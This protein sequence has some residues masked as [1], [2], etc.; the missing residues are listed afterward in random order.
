MIDKIK[1]LDIP[2]ASALSYSNDSK[3]CPKIDRDFPTLVP[4]DDQM[5]HLSQMTADLHDKMHEVKTAG[6]ERRVLKFDEDD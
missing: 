1:A 2:D 6:M 3:T 4:F 5:Q